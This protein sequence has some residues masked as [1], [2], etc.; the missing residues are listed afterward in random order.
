MTHFRHFILLFGGFQDTSQQ[1]K[2]LQDLWIYDTHRFSWSN[3]APS[4]KPD[5]RSSFSFHPHEAGAVIYGGYSRVKTNV[6]AGKQSK[7]GHGFRSVFK[8]LVHQDTWFL[9]ITQSDPSKSDD[10]PPVVRW[11][12]R[13]R[14]TNHPNPPRAGATQAYHKGRGIVFGGVHDV[15]ESE[16]GIDS[17]FFNDLFAWNIERNRYF[18]LTLRRPRNA[19]RKHFEEQNVKRGRGRTDEEELLRNL[20]ALETK[21][22]IEAVSDLPVIHQSI[23]KDDSPKK[24]PKILLQTMPHPRFNAQLAVQ[25]DVLYIFGGT[26][27]NRDRE[28]TF[29]EMWAVD[30]SKMDFVQQ[31]YQRDLG[32]WQGSDES[33]SDED[34]DE[35]DDS[36]DD[37]FD[38]ETSTAIVT[39]A[40]DFDD[41]HESQKAAKPV[42]PGINEAD[43]SE[44]YIPDAKPEPRPFESLRDFFARTSTTWQDILLESLQGQESRSGQSI[45][46][47]RRVSFDMAEIKWWDCREDIQR[48]EEEQEEAGI[49][50]VISIADRGADGPGPARRR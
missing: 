16:E 38:A 43:E 11:E 39:P 23:E 10:G 21:G 26:F 47:L 15:E 36:V 49:S 13:K 19:S 1:T 48:L 44:S 40:A 8:P 18:L 4:Q 41:L 27:E 25:D 5:P 2:Y 31:I 12:R 22:S 24:P 28:V 3:P 20:E 50:G 46:E 34:S 30:L 45:K 37:E 42:V 35:E 17:E 29:D 9:R 33:S 7:G 32:N 14:P 6:I